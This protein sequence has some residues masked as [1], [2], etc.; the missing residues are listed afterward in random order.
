MAKAKESYT[1]K[2]GHSTNFR[3]TVTDG[4]GKPVVLVFVPGIHYELSKQEV[5]GLTEEID[6]GLL[7]K[8]NC[9]PKGRH[10]DPQE[11]SADTGGVISKLEKKVEDQ[12]AKITDQTKV[13]E[14]L[15]AKI[16]ELEELLDDAELEDEGTEAK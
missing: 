11:V 5:D 15:N 10:K 8:S 14:D 12:A 13:I 7:V 16:D 6:A 2:F 4:K 9:D 1:L 3:R